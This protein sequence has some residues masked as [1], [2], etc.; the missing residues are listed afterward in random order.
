MFIAGILTFSAFSAVSASLSTLGTSQ[1][2]LG[3]SVWL[4]TPF[5]S[6][7][8]RLA[9]YMHLRYQPVPALVRV[10]PIRGRLCLRAAA[11]DFV[12]KFTAI[13]PLPQD[14]SF[15]I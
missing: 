1:C 10:Q 13:S 9:P 8:R 12:W 5:G 6:T 14:E 2:L 7:T 15:T 3:A 11:R 4:L